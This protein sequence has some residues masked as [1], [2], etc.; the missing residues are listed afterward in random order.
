MLFPL[1]L[2]GLGVMLARTETVAPSLGWML[3]AGALLL[4]LSRIPDVE[5]LAVAADALLVIA[6]VPL[7]LQMISGAVS[8]EL[9]PER[10]STHAQRPS[11]VID[12]RRAHDGRQPSPAPPLQGGGGGRPDHG[13]NAAGVP[14]AGR[15]ARPLVFEEACRSFRAPREQEMAWDQPVF[16]WRGPPARDAP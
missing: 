9:R 3:A 2:F 11:A 10:R 1:S 8:G 5:A 4:P 16:A 6:L 15:L 7:G 14:G 13:R 12:T